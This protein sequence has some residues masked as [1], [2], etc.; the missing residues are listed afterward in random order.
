MM[1]KINA[2]VE[3]FVAAWELL[4]GVTN[5]QTSSKSVKIRGFGAKKLR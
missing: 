5:P 4:S 2:F 1:H 3:E